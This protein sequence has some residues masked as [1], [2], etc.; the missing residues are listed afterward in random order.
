MFNN[1]IK[2]GLTNNILTFIY[3]FSAR[4]YHATTID[5]NISILFQVYETTIKQL[6]CILKCKKYFQK[7]L[8][9]VC[10]FIF[11]FYKNISLEP[12]LISSLEEAVGLLDQFDQ[13]D[14]I[15][16]IHQYYQILLRFED[17][18]VEN[19]RTKLDFYVK[20]SRLVIDRN[21]IQQRYRDIEQD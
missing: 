2:S 14:Q 9:L 12:E 7:A 17:N 10:Y 6:Y 20:N 4:I 1:L 3:Q 16:M 8:D 11:G 13:N 18:S 5:S 21:Q 15:S 19:L